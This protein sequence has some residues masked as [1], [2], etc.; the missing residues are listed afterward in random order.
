MPSCLATASAVV[1][2][3]PV[4]MM[5]R[6]PSCVQH[7]DRL[8]RRRLDGSATP[9]SPAHLPSMAT[10][11]TVWPCERS[12]CSR[13]SICCDVDAL[14]R[15]QCGIANRDAPAVDVPRTPLP[16]TD[17]KI[18][19]TCCRSQ[20]RAPLRPGRSPPPADARCRAPD[21]AA[22]AQQLLG[23]D[24]LQPVRSSPASAS[25]P[26]ACRSYPRPAYRPCRS[27]SRASASRNST[28]DSPR[29][30]CRP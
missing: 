18:A 30:R 13:S 24:A 17:S 12:C 10:I 22:I 11:I 4:S 26:S 25:L 15:H 28:P 9:S 27:V 6:S 20:C 8:R 1:R 19:S 5:T 23:V 29:A 16:V 2:L 7:L 21:P 14:V 3:S